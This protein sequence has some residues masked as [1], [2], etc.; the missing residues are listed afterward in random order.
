MISIHSTFWGKNL[1]ISG[2]EA[3]FFPWE[4]QLTGAEGMSQL[5]IEIPDSA[6]AVFL[7]ARLIASHA[8]VHHLQWRPT[9]L[10]RALKSVR[11]GCEASSFPLSLDSSVVSSPSPHP[12]QLWHSSH[13]SFSPGLW[14]WW[15]LSLEHP[16]SSPWPG[17][18]LR[19]LYIHVQVYT[20]TP[21]LQRPWSSSSELAASLLFL[22][23]PWP[24]DQTCIPNHT[25]LRPPC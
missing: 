18:F 20:Q 24:P 9:E 14:T 6:R 2:E 8:S 11:L 1:F 15:F 25:V 23:T 19:T 13:V 10:R 5:A 16:F 4:C 7:Q 22:R 12:P 3:K 21:A 17:Y